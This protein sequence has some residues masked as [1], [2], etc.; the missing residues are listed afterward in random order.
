MSICLATLLCA[1]LAAAPSSAPSAPSPAPTAS[2]TTYVI[3]HGAWGGGWDW[4]KVDDLLS[5]GGSPVFRPTL[6]GLGA[7]FHL[8]TREI[9]LTTHVTDVV[10]EILFEDL[11]DVVLVGHSYGGMVI[12]GVA[13]RVPER[14]RRLVY[15]DAVV[16]EDGDSMMGSPRSAG[17]LL[18]AMVIRLRGMVNDGFLIP[19]WVS[20]GQPFPKDV[21]QPAK[22]FT[23]P[24]VLKNE[25]A[26]RL[27][28]TYILT[29]EKG[30]VKDDFS[31]HAERARSRG[32]TI[33][34]MEADHNPQRTMPEALVKI[35][36]E[37]R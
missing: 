2:G 10:N 36:R 5:A 16:P 34:R 1:A 35:L 31:P 15:L 18:G 12:S 33:V 17:G 28:A 29:V 21:P 19:P 26:R 25:T 3:V 4:R 8:A 20:E 30:A 6:T 13:E 9:G 23:E 37:N 22:T 7:R 14:I 27:P 24:I 11:R 32:W